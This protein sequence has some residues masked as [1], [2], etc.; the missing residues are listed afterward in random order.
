MTLCGPPKLRDFTQ[1]WLLRLL[2]LPVWPDI[3]AFAAQTAVGVLLLSRTVTSLSL[4]QW[5]DSKPTV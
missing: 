2:A 1:E 4:A 3:P 5:L